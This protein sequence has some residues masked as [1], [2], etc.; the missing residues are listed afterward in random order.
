[1]ARAWRYLAA[2]PRCCCAPCYWQPHLQAGDLS[3]HIYNA[4]LVQLIESGRTTGLA[5]APQSTNILFDVML[6]GLLRSLGAEAAQRVSVSVA[7]LALVWGA[8]AFIAVVRAPALGAAAALAML[9]YGWVFHMGFFNFYVSFGLCFWALAL[10]VGNGA[11]AAG[12]RRFPFWRWHIWRIALPVSLEP[13]TG[14][15]CDAGT[16]AGS[17]T[18]RALLTAAGVPGTGGACT[19][20]RATPCPPAGRRYNSV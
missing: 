1:M 16:P 18:C 14:S 6:S 13:G 3:S 20:W 7:V 12:R 10:A 9:A 4:W 15:L 2:S 17:P 5:V 19:R 8:F 11:A